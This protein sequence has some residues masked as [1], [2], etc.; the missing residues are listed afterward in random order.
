MQILKELIKQKNLKEAYDLYKK[1]RKF[2]DNFSKLSDS[3]YE[4]NNE[5]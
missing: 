2:D 5:N 3:K 1:E 4:E